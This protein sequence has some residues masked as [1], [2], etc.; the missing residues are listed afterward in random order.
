[1]G[2]GKDVLIT[3]GTAARK[4][5][6]DEWEKCYAWLDKHEG[7]TSYL[8]KATKKWP[9]QSAAA[10]KYR[11]KN[12][13]F[14]EGVRGPEPRLTLEGEEAFKQWVEFQQDV[15]NCVGAE[16]MG[17]EAATW[18]KR[19]GIERGVGGRKWVKGFFKRN[20]GL[21]ERQ[22]QLVEACRLTAMNPPAIWRFYDIAGYAMAVND[23][24]NEVPP[25]RIYMMDEVGVQAVHLKRKHKVSAPPS[26]IHSPALP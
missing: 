5:T 12:R 18:G 10:L 20:P 7:Q 2:G 24:P 25:E 16:S 3:T 6:R 15:G 4:R 19:L 22:S 8:Q 17:Q 1:L 23:P 21:A 9:G 26:A 13:V 11:W 14:R